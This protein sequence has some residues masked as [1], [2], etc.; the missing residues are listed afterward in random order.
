MMIIMTVIFIVIIMMITMMIAMI[1]VSDSRN[2]FLT[3]F[4]IL[5]YYGNDIEYDYNYNDGTNGHDMKH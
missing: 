4:S 3:I 1:I 2:Y 5:Q